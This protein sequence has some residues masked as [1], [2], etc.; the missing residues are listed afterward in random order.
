MTEWLTV[1]EIAGHLRVSKMTIY[2]LMQDGAIRYTK[3][4]RNYRVRREDYV[5]YLQ[6]NT[7]QGKDTDH[8]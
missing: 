5:D 3:L 1:K 4:G 7:S 2:R 8:A 6:A